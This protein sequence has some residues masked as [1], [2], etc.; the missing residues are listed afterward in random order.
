MGNGNVAVNHRQCGFQGLVGGCIV[1]MK[2]PIM[3]APK[4]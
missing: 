4:F 3:D 2:D 1:V